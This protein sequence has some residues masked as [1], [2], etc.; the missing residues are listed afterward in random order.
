MNAYLTPALLLMALVDGAAR[1]AA[2][3]PA[4]V[5]RPDPAPVVE[6]RSSMCGDANLQGSCE[7]LRLRG[8]TIVAL[9][10]SGTGDAI[11]AA[12][13]ECTAYLQELAAAS[14]LLAGLART[15][16][17]D[18][19]EGLIAGQPLPLDVEADNHGRFCR[20]LADPTTILPADLA[21]TVVPVAGGITY[22]AALERARRVQAPPLRMSPVVAPK[23]PP[24]PAS[25]LTI[26]RKPQGEDVD[27]LRLGLFYGGVTGL[28]LGLSLGGIGG[29]LFGLWWRSEQSAQAALSSSEAAQHSQS[30]ST[31][32][33][34]GI[35]VSGV[36]AALL[37]TGVILTIAS[38]THRRR[39]GTP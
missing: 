30:A 17:T 35:A 26:A 5:P 7:R 4:P 29:G 14:A 11:Q 21:A 36:G 27:R 16:R 23:S 9:A 2:A 6:E 10:A 19:A 37:T 15:R 34:G 33:Q 12:L 8:R 18:G 1:S 38:K 28:G 24:A 25:M 22:S 31:F 13:V 39:V 3:A 20:V 32:L